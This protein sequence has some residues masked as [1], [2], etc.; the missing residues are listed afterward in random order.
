M[1]PVFLIVVLLFIGAIFLTEGQTGGSH[2]Y[3]FLN[4]S[5]SA[6]TTA[7]GGKLIAQK[8]ND[9]SLAGNN[10]SL[11]NEKMK[12]NLTLSYT[13]LYEG[14]TGINYG[15]VSYATTIKE[16]GNV[17]GGL[18]YINYG[19]FQ[20][21]DETGNKTNTFG[22]SEY[23]FHLMW[24]KSLDSAFSIGVDVKPLYST[25]ESYYSYGIAVDI[26]VTYNDPKNLFTAAL[27]VKNGGA[28]LTPYVNQRE[29]LPFEVQLGLSKK[30]QYAPFRFFLLFQHLETPDMSN[31]KTVFSEETLT[32]EANGH[33]SGNLGDK[34]M[35]HVIVGTEFTPF[36][37]F[38][39]RFAY[40]YQRRQELK[41]D[42]RPAMVGYSW[43]FGIK[44]S[45]F[46]IDYGRS[47]AHL[48]GGI[49]T[50]TISTNFSDFYDK[51]RIQ[52]Q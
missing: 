14:Y 28:Q 41:I 10:P 5:L 15:Y 50:F 25:L 31:S 4:L 27:V 17:A 12:N 45:K 39:L 16:F 2:T 18:Q 6:R 30:L 11:L 3:D 51:D 22:A 43:G 13:P 40:N 32:Q 20:G 34:I 37:N 21:T 44:I 33:S 49:S 8:D 26:G 7:L 48:A 24:S 35:R 38:F 52:R 9:L 46:R 23:A 29:S 36:N 19:R 1:R 42:T 47:T